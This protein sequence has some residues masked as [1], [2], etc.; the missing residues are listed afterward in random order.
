MYGKISVRALQ[1]DL[2][3]PLRDKADLVSQDHGH[4][5]GEFSQGPQQPPI[6]DGL[7]S[8]VLCLG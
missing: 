4:P 7:S 1:N 3:T 5:T 6:R 8:A 2:V